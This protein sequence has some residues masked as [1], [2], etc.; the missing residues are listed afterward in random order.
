MLPNRVAFKLF[1]N[2]LNRLFEIPHSINERL[3]TLTSICNS[4]INSLSITTCF[5][6]LT[7]G[8]TLSWT[9]RTP[10][11]RA[12]NWLPKLLSFGKR[13]PLYNEKE[14]T[15]IGE[16]IN[17]ILLIVYISLGQNTASFAF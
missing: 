4:S 10:V 3:R 15:M 12:T 13:T 8:L 11:P 1:Y 9:E 7:I 16:K 2:I 6:P 17:L 5:F 14:E